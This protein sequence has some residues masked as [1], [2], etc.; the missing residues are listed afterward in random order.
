MAVSRLD[1]VFL[2]HLDKDHISGV[3]EILVGGSGDTGNIAEDKMEVGIF[4]VI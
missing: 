2:T 4:L 1:A 3:M